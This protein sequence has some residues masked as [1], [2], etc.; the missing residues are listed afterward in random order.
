[1][2]LVDS[3]KQR[4][5]AKKLGQV[6]ENESTLIKHDDYLKKLI[7]Q[8]LAKGNLQE[9]IAECDDLFKEYKDRILKFSSVEE[10]LQDMGML[11]TII[12]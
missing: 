1:M 4:W 6:P 5:D 10:F 2:K 3:V 11:D 8:F 7:E 9:V 12:A